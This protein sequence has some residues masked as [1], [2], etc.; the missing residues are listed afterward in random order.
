MA[1]CPVSLEDLHVYYCAYEKEHHEYCL[2]WNIDSLDWWTTWR[3][4]HRCVRR[5]AVACLMIVSCWWF[6]E[7]DSYSSSLLN[8]LSYHLRHCIWR[9]H[10]PCL[11]I[12]VNIITILFCFHA[13]I[14]KL[15]EVAQRIG[16]ARNMSRSS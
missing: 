15:Y 8:C 1:S 2:Y 10:I 16:G 12:A 13:D 11:Q 7:E 4:Y 6:E 9:C 3:P 5:T 14:H